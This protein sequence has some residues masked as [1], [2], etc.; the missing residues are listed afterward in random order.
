M[1]DSFKVTLTPE[2]REL[3]VLRLDSDPDKNSAL[4]ERPAGGGLPGLPAFYWFAR[5]EKEKASAI[6]LARHESELI[7]GSDRNRLI[8]AYMNY[9]RGRSF[10]SAVDNTWRWRAGYDSLYFSRLWGQVIRFVASGRLRGNTPRY[11]IAT[12]K[13]VYKIGETVKIDC[14][15]FDADMKPSTDST[16]TVFHRIQGREGEPPGRLELALSE[17]KGLGSYEGAV[18]AS[19]RGRHDIWLGSE[20]ER[21]AF[22]SFTVEIPALESR[23]PRLNRSLLETIAAASG[24][25]YHELQ[26]A[27]D[28]VDRVEGVARSQEGS[29]DNDDLWD[30]WWIAVVFTGLLSAEWIL[31]KMARLL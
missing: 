21:L 11:S 4:W 13:T 9:G 28:V 26:D 18:A 8:F 17:A 22:R 19:L 3:P 6:V 25:E 14:R 1:S 24:G 20:E 15:V 2:G 31:R 23:D 10:F 29:I 12:D 27:L 30:E 7:P 16:V 5:L